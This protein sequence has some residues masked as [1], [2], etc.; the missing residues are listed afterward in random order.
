M[1]EKFRNCAKCTCYKIVYQYIS[2]CGL[3]WINFTFA[4]WIFFT[5]LSTLSSFW[6]SLFGKKLF[7]FLHFNFCGDS[8][9]LIFKTHMNNAKN[10]FFI[11]KL[12]KKYL[13]HM[14]PS[15]ADYYYRARHFYRKLNFCT[16]N[17]THIH[18][19]IFTFSILLL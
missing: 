3:T 17:C 10:L 5:S 1:I 2:N 4:S 6:M 14:I 16:A 18:A 7:Y 9:I 12:S 15:D 8:I 19:F 13:K 11:Y